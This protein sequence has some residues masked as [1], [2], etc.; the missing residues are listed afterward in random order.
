M[1]TKGVDVSYWQKEIDWNKVKASGIKFA[2]IRCGYG[3]GGVDSYFE[4]NVKGC[5]RVGIPWGAYYFSY[6][7]SVEE[8]KREL[9]NCLK[10][11]KGKKPSYPVYYDLEDEATTGSQSNSTILKMAKVFVNGIEK[12][13][14]WAG[15]YA[16]TNW[17]NTRL[18]DSWYDR[19]AK[20]VAQYNDKNTYKKSYGIWQYTSSGKVN[21]ISGNVD[22]NYCYVDYPTK[23]KGGAT[24]PATPS[25]PSKPTTAVVKI[26]TPNLKDY[27]KEGDRNL[28]V[29]SYKQL[30]A[31]LK[32]KGIIAQGVDNNEIFGAGTRTATKQ[33]QKAAKIEVD[34]LAGAKTL[35]ACYVL[36]TK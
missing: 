19:K 27:L 29:Y 35:R 11:L 25:K 4:R 26:E 33:V 22:M 15:I 10:L 18:T 17:F 36:L 12:A 14:Y 30:L 20:W 7:E 31:L 21:G 2:I 3:N 16:N 6:A 28:A 1:A 23:I 5:E 8:A 34:G 24:K 13:G 9:D 32:K